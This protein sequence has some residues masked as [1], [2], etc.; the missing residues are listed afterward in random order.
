MLLC[1]VSVIVVKGC[2]VFSVC[3]GRAGVK[4][5]CLVSSCLVFRRHLI[6]SSVDF[7]TVRVDATTQHGS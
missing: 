4:S 7:V 1:C 3:G 6:T 2:V 5:I